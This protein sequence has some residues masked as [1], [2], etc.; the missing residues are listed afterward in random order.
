MEHDPDTMSEMQPPN[1]PPAVA[2]GYESDDIEE[3]AAKIA[4]LTGI[5]AKELERYLA[6]KINQKN[7]KKS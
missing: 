5:K 2:V 1:K 3:L 6:G 7:S 4:N